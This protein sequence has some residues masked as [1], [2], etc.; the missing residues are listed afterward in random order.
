MS[1]IQIGLNSA[2]AA[3]TLPLRLASRHGLVTGTTRTGTT[4][5]LQRLAEEFSATG[6]RVFTADIKG[7]LSG[8]AVGGRFPVA[9]WDIFGHHRLLG[10]STLARDSRPSRSPS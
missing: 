8:V 9:L 1:V 5:T 6:V 10:A 3:V 4:I 7:D 2:G